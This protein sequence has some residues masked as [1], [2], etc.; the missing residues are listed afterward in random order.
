MIRMFNKTK[1]AIKRWYLM[2][3]VGIIFLILGIW[4]ITTPLSAY[5]ALSTVFALGFIIIGITEIGFALD[6]RHQYWGW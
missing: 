3:I 1:K 2:L 6:N 4:T 5:A